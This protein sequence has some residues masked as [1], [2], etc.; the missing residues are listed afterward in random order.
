MLNFRGFAHALT[1]SSGCQGDRLGVLNSGLH[2][3]ERQIRNREIGR[4]RVWEGGRG[5]EGEQKKKSMKENRKFVLREIS[6]REAGNL[7]L[8]KF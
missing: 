6:T 7:Y 5:R 2:T 1:L 4:G 3:T 8:E